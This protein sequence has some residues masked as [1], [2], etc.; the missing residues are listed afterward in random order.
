MHPEGVICP[1]PTPTT[2]PEGHPDIDGLRLYTEFLLE[3]GVDGLF[4]CGTIGEFSSLTNEARH[5][6]IETVVE[7]AN[8]TP[9]YAGCGDTSLPNVLDHARKANQAGADA[10]VVVTPYYQITTQSGIRR[11]YEAVIDQSPLPII[12]Y[13]LPTLVGTELSTDLVLELSEYEN[14]LGI[15]DSSGDLVYLSELLEN[16]PDSFHVLQG[17]TELAIPSLELGAAGLVS[18]VGNI[19]P[20]ELS[21]LYRYQQAGQYFHANEIMNEIVYPILCAMD[22]LPTAAAVKH[23][24]SLLGY[25]VGSPLPPLPELNHATRTELEKTFSMVTERIDGDHV[26][27]TAIEDLV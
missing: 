1:I 27:E 19:F 7:V 13:N 5:E 24:V 4:P 20:T 12:L 15:K 18:G 8:G 11:F 6:V 10:V 26:Q 21:K 23:F 16:T 2:G 14:V 25:E 3:N 22:E 17:S 9:V